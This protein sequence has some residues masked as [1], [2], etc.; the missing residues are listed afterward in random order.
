MLMILHHLELKT[1]RVHGIGTSYRKWAK[2]RNFREFEPEDIIQNFFRS[3]G[4]YITSGM[5]TFIYHFSVDH[6]FRCKYVLHFQHEN[7]M[8]SHLVE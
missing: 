1:A 8:V 6:N 2:M 4:L 5:M 3:H 7:G